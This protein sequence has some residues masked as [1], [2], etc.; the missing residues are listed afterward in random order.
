MVSFLLLTTQMSFQD[1]LMGHVDRSEV[2]S[3]SPLVSISWVDIYNKAALSVD[4]LP[5]VRKCG[6]LPHRG[7]VARRRAS[8]DPSSVGRRGYYGRA[9]MSKGIPRCVL[10]SSLDY[11]I[12]DIFK[13]VPRILDG[14]LPACLQPSGNDND[15]WTPFGQYLQTTRINVNVRQVFPKGF[16]PLEASTDSY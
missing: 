9:W 7:I 13:G 3:T 11:E 14:T 6:C 10:A 16:N 12:F 8:T 15:E 2:C 5:Q 1:T 4:K